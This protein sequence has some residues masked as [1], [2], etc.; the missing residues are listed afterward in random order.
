M[1]D[2]DPGS[3]HSFQV[4]TV[5][6]DA[7]ATD[8]SSVE[9]TTP[10]EAPTNVAVTNLSSEGLT[11]TWNTAEDSY[12]AYNVYSVSGGVYTLLGTTDAGASSY[13]ISDVT[14]GRMCSMR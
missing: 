9:Q 2:L 11:V 10:L 13:V 8:S 12:D 1:S 3:Y 7:T 5:K 4:E 14:P 6:D